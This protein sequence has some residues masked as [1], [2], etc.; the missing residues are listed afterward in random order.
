MAVVFISIGS[1]AGERRQNCL[2]ALFDL[3]QPQIGRI[4]GQSKFY[5]SQPVD[6][7]QQ[8]WFVN[9][10]VRLETDLDPFALLDAAK[11]IETKLGRRESAIRFGP[12]VIDLDIILYND[13]IIDAP[14]LTIPH[15]RMHKRRFVL[16][17]MCDIDDRI[18]HPVL[19][20]PLAELLARL[21]E[22]DQKLVL[23]T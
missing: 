5:L 13:R 8:N 1:N 9:A 3:A 10:A 21:C 11:R 19:H 2:Q 6:Y 16:Q 15:P 14:Q 20:E 23:M 18:V 12:R 4:T 17:P 22:S 7:L